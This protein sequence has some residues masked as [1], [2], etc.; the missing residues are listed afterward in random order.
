MGG[1]L[2]VVIFRLDDQV[3]MCMHVC[4]YACMHIFKNVYMW[5]FGG[6]CL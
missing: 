2:A 5:I 6:S 3:Y 1:Y 4:V